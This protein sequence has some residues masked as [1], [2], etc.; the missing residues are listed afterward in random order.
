MEFDTIRYEVDGRIATITLNRPDQ[1]N[2]INPQMTADLRQ[3]YA[4][5]EA[6]DAV[7]TLVITAMG[8]AFCTGA[9]VGDISDDFRVIYEGESYL[10]TLPQWEAPQEGTPPFRNMTKPII[11]AVNGLCC[12]A[13]LDWVTTG[14]V[15]IAS[16]RAQFFDPH[17]SIGLVSARESVRLARVL[18]TNIA[19]RIAITGRHERMG[20]QRAYELGLISEVV[21]HDDL[22]ERALE[23]AE[24]VNRNAPLA[25]RGT[26]L[27][28]RKGL[29]VP[30]HE[31]EIMAEA[32]RERV[33]Y[34]KDAREGPAAFLEK[35]DPNWS[36]S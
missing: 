7:W 16:E 27:A 13:G 34:T 8:R 31:A 30:L 11:V 4:A 24:L 35:R 23:I 32:F 3:A 26:R 12:G 9:D 15:V 14:D 25:V 17:V 28:I 22:V 5:A 19:M 21:D 18:P 33:L 20:A 1:L 36:A 6:D 10:A 2:A 29:D